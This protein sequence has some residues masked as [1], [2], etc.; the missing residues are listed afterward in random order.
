MNNKNIL[1]PIKKKKKKKAVPS[2]PS[3]V[4]ISNKLAKCGVINDEYQLIHIFSR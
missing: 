1:Y 4:E 2:L 3:L